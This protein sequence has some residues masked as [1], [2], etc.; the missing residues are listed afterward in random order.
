MPGAVYIHRDYIPTGELMTRVE[1]AVKLCG[2]NLSEFD[3]VKISLTNEN[4][5]FVWCE[6][7]D[8]QAEPVISRV[9]TIGKGAPTYREYGNIVYHHKWLMVADDYAGFDIEV[10]KIRTAKICAIQGLDFNRCGKLSVWQEIAQVHGL[11][12]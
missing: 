6:D 10:S 9:L 5:S 11:N 7:F 4:I 2:L 12:D 1:A 8:G 3:V